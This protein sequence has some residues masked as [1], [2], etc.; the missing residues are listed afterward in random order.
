MAMKNKLLGRSRPLILN[1]FKD[2]PIPERAGYRDE[3]NAEEEF[4]RL[5]NPLLFYGLSKERQEILIKWCKQLEPTKY[6]TD[7]PSSYKLK[8]IFYD[9]DENGFYMV[10]G[11]F[12]GAMIC[13]GFK[14]QDPTDLNWN[15][16]ISK[17]SIKNIIQSSRVE[18]NQ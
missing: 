3:P 12:K 18:D 8:H 14:V 7:T 11:V 16:N 10:N 1:Q 13:A 9:T 15:F 5:D 6:Y 2:L 17:K 4:N